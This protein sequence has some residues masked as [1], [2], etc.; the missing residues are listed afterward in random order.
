MHVL[1]S[2]KLTPVY[3]LT[4]SGK[5]DVM[6]LM[7][8]KIIQYVLKKGSMSSNLATILGGFSLLHVKQNDVKKA[9]GFLASSRCVGLVVR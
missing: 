7:N 9:D 6:K 5:L 3:T 1:F 4:D 8:W 2:Q